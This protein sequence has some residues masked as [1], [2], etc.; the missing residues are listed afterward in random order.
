[1]E[2][3][4]ATF[5]KWDVDYVK[6]D[7]CYADIKDM[8]KGYPEFGRLLNATGR[9]MIYSCSWPVYQEYLGLT[10]RRIKIDYEL[11]ATTLI[12]QLQFQPNYEALKTHCNLW[13]NWGDIQDSYESLRKITEYFAANQSRIQPHA[14]PGHWNDPD[15]L[16][17]GNF[18]LTIEQSKTQM[19]IWAILAAPLIMSNDLKNVRP[20]F[21]EILLNK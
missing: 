9:P 11:M 14:G 19:A 6:L 16:I 13:R 1:M 7:G 5:G 12:I 21:E 2:L 20:E 17:I 18:G 4:A 3:D 10:V 8:D 15:M